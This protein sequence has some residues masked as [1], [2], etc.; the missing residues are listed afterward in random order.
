MRILRVVTWIP[1]SR[2][3]IRIGG[4]DIKKFG[5]PANQFI[6]G[7]HKRVQMFF[8]GGQ[9]GSNTHPYDAIRT[10]ALHIF[11]TSKNSHELSSRMYPLCV[12]H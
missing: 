6:E 11:A 12:L 4:I 10:E 7:N 2:M 9:I 5:V 1:V 8:D 3:N